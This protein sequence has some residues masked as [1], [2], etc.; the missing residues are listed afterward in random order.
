MQCNIH[1]FKLKRKNK[2]AR[3]NGKIIENNAPRFVRMAIE[4]GSD[5][6][7]YCIT[8]EDRAR[9]KNGGVEQRGRSRK[10]DEG[11]GRAG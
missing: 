5:P 1:N 6:S 4:I 10:I 3:E 11:R 2:N 9:T 7:I 8:N